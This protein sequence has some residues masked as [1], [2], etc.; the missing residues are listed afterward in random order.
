[1]SVNTTS[2]EPLSEN[3]SSELP[4]DQAILL[5]TLCQHMHIKQLN[6]HVYSV[7]VVFELAG[8]KQTMTK[9]VTVT[10]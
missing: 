5:T 9:R 7:K 4:L 2:L 10:E 8:W 1:M 3:L 6:T